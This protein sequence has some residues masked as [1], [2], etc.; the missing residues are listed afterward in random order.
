MRISR[1]ASHIAAALVAA[2]TSFTTL[3]LFN[4]NQ[5]K[6]SIDNVYDRVLKTGRI[7]AGYVAYPPA[8]IVDPHSK[9][10]TGIFPDLLRE[11][12]KITNFEISFTEEV[13]WATLIEGLET[14]RY[15]IVGGVWANPARGRMT[16]ISAPAYYT[17][18]GVWVRPDETRFTAENGWASINS[19]DIKIGA[20]DGS[21]PFNI[22]RSQFPNAQLVSYPNLTSES[23]LFLDV[24]QKKVD[25]FFAEPAQGLL[26]LKH[27]PGALK[28]LGYQHPLRVFGSVFLMRRSEPQFKTMIDTAMA[29]L[30]SIGVVETLIKKYEPAE[31]TFLRLA[32]PYRNVPKAFPHM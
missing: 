19:K 15:D 10:V 2:A 25:V 30:Q 18:I 21:T 32:R 14:G 28:N 26:F 23:Q 12:G 5:A 22:A 1:I 29:E 20:I 3:W 24:V 16:T 11:I 31:N 4:G 6:V 27:N 13:G 17:A 9:S 8:S 7:R